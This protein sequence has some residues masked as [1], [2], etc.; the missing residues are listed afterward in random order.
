MTF[1]KRTKKKDN[2]LLILAI[3]ELLFIGVYIGVDGWYSSFPLMSTGLLILIW[4]GRLAMAACIIIT[5]VKFK[6]PNYD[7]YRW[8]VVVLAVA[9]TLTIGIHH[10]TSIEDKQVI[11]DSKENAQKP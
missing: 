7:K 4:I 1:E 11:I 5:W 9:L 2:E 8:G 10:A 3:I 6:D